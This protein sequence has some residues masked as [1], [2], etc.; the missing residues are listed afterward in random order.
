MGGPSGRPNCRKENVYTAAAAGIM[1]NSGMLKLNSIGALAYGI[2]Q[3]DRVT[4]V[5][6]TA[7]L[8]NSVRSIARTRKETCN[9]SSNELSDCRIRRCPKHGSR[10]R[11]K[12]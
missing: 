10:L 4:I 9:S 5:I 11:F 8:R 1:R 2:R 7:I 6:F 3:Q 12:R